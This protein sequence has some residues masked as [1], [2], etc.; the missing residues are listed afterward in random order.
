MLL[1]VRTITPQDALIAAII[2]FFVFA[3]VL[4]LLFMKN[5]QDDKNIR[6]QKAIEEAKSRKE[7]RKAFLADELAISNYYIPRREDKDFD[8]QLKLLLN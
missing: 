3:T 6:K 7:M 1:E 5:K 2:V 4:F 8:K